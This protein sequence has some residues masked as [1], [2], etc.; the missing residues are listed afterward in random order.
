MQTAALL[1]FEGV[2]H[3]PVVSDDEV[4]VGIVSTIDV[5]RTLARI[6]GYSVPDN[7]QLQR[8]ASLGFQSGPRIR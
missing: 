1:A 6:D 5:M 8:E 2:H 7:I 4:L 3:I